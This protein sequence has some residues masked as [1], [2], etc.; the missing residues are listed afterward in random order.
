M[1]RK[2]YTE[3]DKA[4][5]L[6]ICVQYTAEMIGKSVK[7]TARTMHKYGITDWLLA[8]Y[9]SFHTQGYEYMAEIISDKLREE[10]ERESNSTLLS[11]NN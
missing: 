2:V 10:Q 6:V 9:R 7:D 11:R 1:K 4:T 8:G 5:W 3:S